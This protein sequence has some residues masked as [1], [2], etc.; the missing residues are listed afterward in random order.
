M[1]TIVD[2]HRF[3]GFATLGILTYFLAEWLLPSAMPAAVIITGLAVGLIGLAPAVRRRIPT[4]PAALLS[5]AGPALA[6]S[7]VLTGRSL[8]T[9][10]LTMFVV[11]GAAGTLLLGTD[12]KLPVPQ[13]VLFGA[14]GVLALVGYLGQIGGHLALDQLAIYPILIAAMVLGLDSARSTS[15]AEAPV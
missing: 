11:L 14:A 5:A 15:R 6:L 9:A 10:M 13:R 2:H 8:P 4:A 3:S 12:T 1:N 7:G